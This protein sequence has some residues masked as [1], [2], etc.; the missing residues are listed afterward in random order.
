MNTQGIA[1]ATMQN[2]VAVVEGGTLMTTSIK[3]AEAFGKR[4][5]HVLDKIQ[6]LGCSPEFASANFSAHEDIAVQCASKFWN[7]TKDGF[8]FLV[9]GFTV[10]RRPKAL[11]Q[12]H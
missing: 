3:V 2:L 9:M 1:P 12:S 8:I 4:H 11:M 7:M 6:T 10:T 5:T